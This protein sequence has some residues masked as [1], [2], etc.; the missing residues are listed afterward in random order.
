MEEY[1]KLC[2]GASALLIW[3]I[4]LRR[5]F[6]VKMLWVGTCEA[7][8]C[9]FCDFNV[10]YSEYLKDNF[11]LDELPNNIACPKT[12]WCLHNFSQRTIKPSLSDFS[13][14]EI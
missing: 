1:T 6:I 8:F 3:L 4:I 11:A 14:Q 13:V 12:F 2:A 9:Y 10:F 5:I 7:H